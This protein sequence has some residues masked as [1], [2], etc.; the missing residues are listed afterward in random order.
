MADGDIVLGRQPVRQGRVPPRAGH[1]RHRPS[2]DRGP[3][4]HHAAARRLR[5]L[6]HRRATTARSSRP[7][8]RRTP[9]TPSPASTA[10]A[11]PRQ[12]L[13][14]LG[15]HFV[16]DFEWVSGGRWEAEQFAWQRIPVDGAAARPRVRAHRPRRPAPPSSSSTATRTHVVSGLKD[17]TVLKS[18]GSEFHGF[19]RDRYTTLAETDDRILATSVTAWWRYADASRH[20]LRRGLRRRSGR[21]LLATF[22]TV[23]SL[24]LQQTIFAMGKAVLEAYP[25][26]RRDQ[27]LVPQQAPL[28]GRPR[29]VRARQPGRGL[30][31]RRPA[32]RADRGDR[33]ARGRARVARSLGDRARV[34]LRCAI[35]ALAGASGCC[36]D[37]RRSCR[38]RSP[39]TTA[40][41][42]RSSPSTTTTDGVVLRV[43]DSAYVVPGVVD[44]HVHINE[45]GR[46]EWEGFV[47]ATEAAALGGATTLIDMPL[48]S[49]PPTTTRRPGCGPSR[50]PRDGELMVDVGLLGRRRPG[51]LRRPRAA[52][53]RRGLRLQVLPVAVG[54]RRVPAARPGASSPAALTEIARFDGL[55]IVHAEDAARARGR[56]PSPPSR[57]YADFLL[58]RPDEA[59][60]DRDPPG[61]STAPARPVRGCTSCTCPAP[62]RST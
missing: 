48:N 45:P 27:A 28:P 58:S 15:R 31:R 5:G 50:R 57:A 17:C 8:P 18:T 61:R 6:P 26:G 9:S 46:T 14:T 43:P 40:G 2:R 51:N 34:L 1:P 20:R 33:P 53:G 39:S 3:Q 37:E 56:R 32:L 13:L 36:V 42:R 49:I 44:T 16:D 30:L 25:R 38:P 29:A 24:A 41:S 47:S 59:E 54:R 19:P 35:D 55:M 22:A 10:S 23:H 60:I 7:T 62:G 4:R 21:P 11:R 52:V 12:F